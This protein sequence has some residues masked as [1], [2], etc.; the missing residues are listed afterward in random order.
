MND[1]T[2][3]FDSIIDRKNTG[4]IKW[5][6]MKKIYNTDDLIPL[7]IADMDFPSPIEVSKA[8]EDRSKH[9]VYG[10]PTIEEPYYESSINW[11]KRRHNIDVKREWIVNT[12]GVVPAISL[13]VLTLTNEEDGIIIQPPVYPPFFECV[14]GNNRRILENN[15]INNDGYYEMDF[16]DLE[17]KASLDYVKMLILCNPHNPVGRVWTKCELKRLKEI[18]LRHNVIVLSDEIHSDLTYKKHPYTSV[19]NLGGEF[20]NN[21]LTTI[22]PSKTFNIAGLFTSVIVIP[23]KEKRERFSHLVN[24]LHIGNGSIFGITGLET[25]YRYGEKWL[26]S[27]LV[28]LEDNA[29][30][31]VNFINERIP[32]IKVM[33]PEGTYLAWLD[34][35]EVFTS[36]SDL[37]EFLAHKAKVGL[38]DGGTFG[39]HGEGFA[40]LNFAC[41]RALLK[42]GLE[43][44][45][46]AVNNLDNY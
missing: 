7:W 18:C 23:D 2:I 25:A 30:F 4:C 34:F 6:G 5:D 14:K 27:L 1:S 11:I 8:L 3:N 37:R 15:L 41:P 35:R 19:L 16:E 44:I 24:V 29:D 36:S 42:E 32:Q 46:E 26:D 12:P 22:A 39:I 33:K 31:L 45:A 10:Y 38:N 43:R 9:Y 20:L 40:R 21:T 17:K 28:Y 13:A